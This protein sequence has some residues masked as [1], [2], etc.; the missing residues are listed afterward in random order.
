MAGRSQ[1]LPYEERLKED[2]TNLL[3][4]TFSFLRLGHS[5]GLITVNIF[6]TLLKW[7]LDVLRLAGE[8]VELTLVLK[9]HTCQVD[10]VF[11][12]II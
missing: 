10:N 4:S 5:I 1:K 12:K 8:K 3:F 7:T 11:F 6:Y 9:Q 2:R